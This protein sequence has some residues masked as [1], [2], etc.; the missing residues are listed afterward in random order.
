[1]LRAAI[2]AA[3][4]EAMP[5]TLRAATCLEVRAPTWALV[6]ASTWVMLS[7]AIWSVVR[8]GSA[9]VPRAAI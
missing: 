8:P 5:A 9:A 1:M 7:A 3:E 4:S 6:R 2:W